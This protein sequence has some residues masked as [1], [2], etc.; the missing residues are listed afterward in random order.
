VIVLVV[1]AGSPTRPINPTRAG[2]SASSP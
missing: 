2:N 1:E